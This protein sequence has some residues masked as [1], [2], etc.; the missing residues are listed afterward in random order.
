MAVNARRLAADALIRVHQEGSYSN[1]VLDSLLNQAR[2]EELNAVD[3]TLVSRLFYGVLER[4]LT[5]DYVVERHS[6]VRLKKMH[7][8]VLE[9]LRLGS[10]Q[11]MYMDKIPPSAA[12]NETVK[13]ARIMKQDRAA[14]LINAVLR[15]IDRDRGHWLDELPE[16]DE[17]LS[18]R[19][20]CPAPLIA[21]WRQAYG[22][23]TAER[24]AV[25]ANEA[26]PVTIRLNTLKTTPSAFESAL[27]SAGIGYQKH[28]AL[29]YCYTIHQPAA[30]KGL[31]KIGENWYYHQDAASQ[32]CCLALDARPGERIAD[33]CAAPGGKSLTVAQMMNNQGSILSCDIHAGKCDAMQRRAEKMGAD[34]MTTAVRDASSPCPEALKGQFDRVLC[35]APCSGLGVIRRKPEI[36]YKSLDSF[37]ELPAL[38]SA[39]LHQYA[40]MVRTGGVLQYSTCTLN[41]AENERVAERFLREHPEFSPRPLPLREVLPSAEDSAMA[42][43]LPPVHGTDGF[44][45]AGFMKLR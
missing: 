25:S 34:C 9:L 29:P 7:P 39:I 43:L 23:E 24:L 30:L 21:L 4:L 8:T 22:A 20:S 41:P 2:L 19:T 32:I 28:A 10:Y 45:I 33:V 31:A 42:T 27:D 5:L 44:F 3:R 16:G 15:A 1:V 40:Q 14:G 13:L 36:R 18:I 12:V 38:Q 26:P 11:L 6:S 35:D 37:K 17:G